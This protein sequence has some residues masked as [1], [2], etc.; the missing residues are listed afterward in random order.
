MKCY[1]CDREVAQTSETCPACGCPTD[2][3]RAVVAL[4]TRLLTERIE[5]ESALDQL[6]KAKIAM[7]AAA[8]FALLNGVVL[9]T[10]AQSGLMLAL[11]IFMVVLAGGY[12]AL[13][14]LVRKAPLVLS[15][16]G[17]VL[18]LFFV[19]GVI[20]LVVIGAMAISVFFAVVYTRSANRIDTLERKIAKLK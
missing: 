19:G 2:R 1:D 20:G 6:H 5:A 11:G 8:F 3:Q 15:I 18:S 17:L 7:F 12:V 4:E 16:V 10:R 14:L 13:G 9:L